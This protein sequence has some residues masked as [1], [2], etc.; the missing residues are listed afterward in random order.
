MTSMS[1]GQGGS[2]GGGKGGR[3]DTPADG[4][5][6]DTETSCFALGASL[7]QLRAAMWVALLGTIPSEELAQL[8]AV[9]VGEVALVD[10]EAHC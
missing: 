5:S 7:S 4:G 9:D 6:R 1:R 3:L 2:G 10:A 8:V